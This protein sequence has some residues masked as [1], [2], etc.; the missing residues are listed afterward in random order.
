MRHFIIHDA[1]GKI[2]RCGFVE[3]SSPSDIQDAE[4]EFEIE[5]ECPYDINAYKISNNQLVEKTDAEKD[6]DQQPWLWPRFRSERNSLLLQS[7]WTQVSDAPVDASAWA[8][9]RQKLRDLPD[10]VDINN[11][12]WPAKPS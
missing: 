11:I 2:L 7:D 10:T 12:L 1:N 5:L 9:Y 4:N 8:N 6:A 3:D